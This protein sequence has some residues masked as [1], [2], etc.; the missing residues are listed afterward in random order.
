M[1]I[2]IMQAYFLPYIGYFQQI[3]L[4]DQFVIYDNIEFSKK[5]WIHR[6]RF[7]QNG[8]AKYFSL[9]LKKDSDYLDI[10][11][12]FLSEQFL[13]KDANKLVAQISNA[14]RK[15]PFYKETIPLVEK[16]FKK[17]ESNLFQFVFH[18]ILSVCGH[19]EIDTRLLISSQLGVDHRSLKGQE[20]VLS[21]NKALKADIYVNTSSGKDLYQKEDFAQAGIEL[22]FYDCK[23]IQYDQ[24]DGME[25]IPYL[26]IIDYLM[27]NGKAN[28]I[29][30]LDD[31]ELN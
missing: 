21:I 17:E 20:K 26:S 7:I 27:F 24:F 13:K 9:S 19:L 5:G 30:A 11:E 12:R 15:A 8:Q 31:Y 18:S 25:F 28:T 23:A 6:N 16:C 22:K 3:H 2:G 1:T 10:N 29:K 4:A 14:Y